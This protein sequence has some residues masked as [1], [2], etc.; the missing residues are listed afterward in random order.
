MTANPT[1]ERVRSGRRVGWTAAA[2]AA[3]LV[4]L[5]AVWL[6]I[7]ILAEDDPGRPEV[8]TQIDEIT[9]DPAAFY[10]ERVVVTGP[11]RERIGGG[12][13]T[14]GEDEL[15]VVN[16]DLSGEVGTAGL[17]EVTGV[18]RPLSSFEDGDP[19]LPD[20]ESLGLEGRPI[21]VAEDAE[22]VLPPE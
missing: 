7:A 13:L 2:I 10:G 21:L 15:L 18:V 8:G 14:I 4:A 6:G 9:D 3:G 5:A 20:I 11:V 1:T 17:I 22:L 19:L 12:A 16:A